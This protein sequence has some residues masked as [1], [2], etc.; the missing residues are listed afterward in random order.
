MQVPPS[1]MLSKP[2]APA[3]H[4]TSLLW[5][6]ESPGG[7]HRSPARGPVLDSRG[8][9][10]GSVA[11]DLLLYV[12][13]ISNCSNELRSGGGMAKCT[14]FTWKKYHMSREGLA[15]RDRAPAQW[16]LIASNRP[17]KASTISTSSIRPSSPLF[18]LD[19][20]SRGA[21]LVCVRG[22]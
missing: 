13:R 18:T 7:K 9:C 22:T 14:A 17:L 19:C 4:G 3:F 8:P 5:V 21:G 12:Q 6:L 20:A 10:G 11:E 16:L 1:F 2:R 15:G